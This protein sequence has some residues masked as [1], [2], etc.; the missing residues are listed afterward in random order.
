MPKI[1]GMRRQI[2]EG[3]GAV[4]HGE[5][6]RQAVRASEE[7][8]DLIAFACTKTYAEARRQLGFGVEARPASEA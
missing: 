4:G 8:R 3:G 1:V 2:G 5:S 7:L 6:L